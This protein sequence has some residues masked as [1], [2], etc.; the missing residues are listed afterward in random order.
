MKNILLSTLCVLTSLVLF[1]QQPP[2]TQPVISTQTQTTTEKGLGE[3]EI[4]TVKQDSK[5]YLSQ[6]DA[7]LIAHMN[8]EI[9]E[10]CDEHGC[11]FVSRVDKKKGWAI[12]FNAGVG[13]QTG[14]AGTTINLGGANQ[15]QSLPYLGVNI[16]YTN[17]KCATDFKIDVDDFIN[18]KARAIAEREDGTYNMKALTSDMKFI[19]L[20]KLEIYKQLAQGGCLN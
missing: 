17:M 4:G 19:Q 2:E 10:K 7:A 1:A 8:A 16:S 14:A 18:N 12:S 11:T 15:N 9:E 13:N 3:L 5:S 20:I 6:T